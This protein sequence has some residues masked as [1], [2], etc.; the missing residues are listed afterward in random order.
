MLRKIPLSILL[1]H[2]LWLS[3]VLFPRNVRACGCLGMILRTRLRG[4]RLRFCS[5]VTSTPNLLSDYNCKEASCQ[6]Q[7]NV[8]T[9]GGLSSQD[10]VSQQQEASR[11]SLPQ[12]NRLFEAS[13]V[14]D[15]SSASNA[16]VTAILS[17]HRVTTR[18]SATGSPSLTSNLCL[19]ARVAL[20]S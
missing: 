4:H 12:L 13:F 14:R 9:S 2:G 19:R 1:L 17:Q 18:Y 8:G 5:F 3:L 15:E 16:A 11:L 7:V 20:N 10:G 6:S